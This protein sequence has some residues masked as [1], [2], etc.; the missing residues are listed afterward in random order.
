MEEGGKGRGK[1]QGGG[2]FADRAAGGQMLALVIREGAGRYLTSA[3]CEDIGTRK[4]TPNPWQEALTASYLGSQSR[5]GML[6][7]NIAEN[8]FPEAGL[9][10]G[11]PRTRTGLETGV[12]Q[13]VVIQRP[14]W[15]EQEGLRA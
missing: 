10:P 11:A 6:P 9:G 14:R 5:L 8:C 3:I 1:A 12:G 15:R 13:Q 7:E 4:S 2:G